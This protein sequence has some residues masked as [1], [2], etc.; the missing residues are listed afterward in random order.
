MRVLARPVGR[1]HTGV[2]AGVK[3][4][5]LQ[6][7]PRFRWSKG[8]VPFFG[9]RDGPRIAQEHHRSPQ[10]TKECFKMHFARNSLLTFRDSQVAK[11]S[12]CF[13]STLGIKWILRAADA[14]CPFLYMRD[15]RAQPGR[16]VTVCILTIVIFL[17]PLLVNSKRVL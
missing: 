15:A 5:V 13:C 6:L 10:M 7:V 16:G 17:K 3:A 14:V 2:Q 9:G 8:A 12:D 4:V 1:D 11:H